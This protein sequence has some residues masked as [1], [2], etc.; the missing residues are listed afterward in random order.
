MLFKNLAPVFLILALISLGVGAFFFFKYSTTQA[1]LSQIKTEV[2]SIKNEV[3]KMEQQKPTTPSP[4]DT[5]SSVPLA[6]PTPSPV[7]AKL[8]IYNG[9]KTVGYST[10]VENDLKTEFPGVIVLN[11]DNSKN[12]YTKK[13]VITLNPVKKSQAEQIATY[14]KGE[15]SSLPAGETK[16]SKNTDILIIAGK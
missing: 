1:E 2:S 4:S 3:Q 10:V 11:K 12:N 15:I 8:T 7:N 16:P 14:L 6:S 9:S 13:L 5:A